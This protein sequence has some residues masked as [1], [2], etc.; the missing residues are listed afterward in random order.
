[1][2]W[3]DSLLITRSRSALQIARLSLVILGSSNA[4]I[5]W[6]LRFDRSRAAAGDEI[7]SGAASSKGEGDDFFFTGIEIAPNRFVWVNLTETA[8]TVTRVEVS[9]HCQ[10]GESEPEY[11]TTTLYPQQL[12]TAPQGLP[13]LFT[14]G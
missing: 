4:S 2:P 11:R 3:S 5:S 8:G 7:D 6:S 1:M 14:I 10:E 12:S 13:L 9:L